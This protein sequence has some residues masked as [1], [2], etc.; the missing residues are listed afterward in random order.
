MKQRH[1]FLTLILILVFALPVLAHE[2]R[3]VG[4]YAITF[5]WRNEPAY[6]GQINGPEVFITLH[7]EDAEADQGDHAEAFPEDVVVDLQAEVTFGDQSTTLVLVPVRDEAGHYVASL[8]P[9]LP[10]DYTFRVFGTIGDVAVDEVFSSSNGE[11]SSVEPLD[12]IRFP[13]IENDTD[14]LID[15]L[16]AR[17]AELEARLAALE[18]E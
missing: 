1:F 13:V 4:D 7:H 11:F 16:E 9:A 18:A 15:A 3:E 14:A 8:L 10:G 17:I 6:A 5:G 12:D 2:G